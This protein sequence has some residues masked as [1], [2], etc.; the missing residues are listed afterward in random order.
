MLS[1]LRHILDGKT[2]QSVYYVTFESHLRNASPVLMQNTN[3]VKRPHLLQKKSLKMLFQNRN[4]HT[5]P[6]FK[7][8]KML[9]LLIRQPLKTAFS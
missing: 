9:S 1:K 7:S 2:L 5:S 6:S 4:S 8:A 3:S